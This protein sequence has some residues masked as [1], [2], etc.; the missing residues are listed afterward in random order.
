MR[1]GRLL[2]PQ[3][4]H[5]PTS[6]ANA[7]CTIKSSDGQTFRMNALSSCIA[8]KGKVLSYSSHVMLEAKNSTNEI[9]WNYHKTSPFDRLF[10][11]PNLIGIDLEE[12]SLFYSTASHDVS[13]LLIFEGIAFHSS[14][15]II[16]FAAIELQKGWKFHWRFAN[17][18]EKQYL[19]YIYIFI[20]IL[21]DLS[22]HILKVTYACYIRL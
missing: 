10:E 18:S 7:T 17:L 16:M 21:Y 6:K 22:W 9:I 20:H 3:F 4:P 1:A 8:S 13:L 12:L 11:Y 5:F 19:S 2:S 15:F 14:I